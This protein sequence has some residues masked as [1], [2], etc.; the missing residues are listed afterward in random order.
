VNHTTPEHYEV[1]VTTEDSTP[2]SMIVRKYRVIAGSRTAAIK[3]VQGL[4]PDGKLLGTKHVP[5][6]S[7]TFEVAD[8]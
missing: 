4:H 8:A 5:A 1:E 6:W 2:V 7:Q 3:H